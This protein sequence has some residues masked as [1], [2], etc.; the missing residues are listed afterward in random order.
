MG[1]GGSNRRGDRFESMMSIYAVMHLNIIFI[2]CHLCLV[3]VILCT[4]RLVEPNSDS[5]WW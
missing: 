4:T 3:A 1:S 5:V 2:P